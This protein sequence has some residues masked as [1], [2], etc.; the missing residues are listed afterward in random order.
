ML[1]SQDLSER[2]QRAFNEIYATAW[3]VPTPPIHVVRGRLCDEL[4]V[5]LSEWS[6]G[7]QD[8]TSDA[9]VAVLPQG[10]CAALFV[11][12]LSFEGR[13]GYLDPQEIGRLQ[14]GV[15]SA[16]TRLVQGWQFRLT[17]P[18]VP[19]GVKLTSA[20]V[21]PGQMG[22]LDILF[23]LQPSTQMSRTMRLFADDLAT[24]IYQGMTTTVVTVTHTQPGPGGQVP[25]PPITAPLR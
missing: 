19:G 15:Q 22:D 13:T 12:V 5:Q 16:F 21:T 18:P 7:A 3:T 6:G 24:A 8:P 9:P 11:P 10:R 25:G 23:P 2:L 20:V 1:R 14:T 17:T 4:G